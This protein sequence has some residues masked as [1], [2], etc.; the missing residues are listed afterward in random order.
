LE[1]G[2]EK[3]YQNLDNMNRLTRLLL[4]IFILIVLFWKIGYFPEWHWLL[5]ELILWIIFLKIGLKSGFIILPIIFLINLHLIHLFVIVDWQYNFDLEKINITN[6]EYF[7]IID[8]YRY[9][10]VGMIYRLRMKFYQNWLVGLLWIDSIA[11]ILSIGYWVKLLGFSGFSLLICGFKK[12]YSIP[13]LFWACV[14]WILTVALSS[15][16]AIMLDDQRA[17]I[18]A[19]IPITFL[20]SKGLSTETFKKYYWVWLLMLIVDLI[21]K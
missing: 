20:I 13:K 9:D 4:Y 16:L 14:I 18:M 19:I 17:W 21:T 7:K 2:G 15:G 8:R 1:L 3:E 10:D 6:P 12:I 11:R 5:L